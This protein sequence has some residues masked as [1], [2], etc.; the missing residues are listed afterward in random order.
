LWQWGAHHEGVRAAEA[1]RDRVTNLSAATLAQVAHDA[2]LAAL[3]LAQA[4]RTVLLAAKS[5]SVAAKRFDVAYNRYV[6][7]R[8]TIDNLYIAQ[9]EKDQALVEYVRALRGYWTAYYRL[10]GAT[11]FDFDSGRPIE[12]SP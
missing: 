9:A 7:G 2:R 8:I 1:D 10:R 12:S 6:I 11:L 5:D 3:A 4:R